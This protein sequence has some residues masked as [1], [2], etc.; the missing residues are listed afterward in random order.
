MPEEPGAHHARVVEDQQVA[1]AQEP[2]KVR[3]LEIP[4]DRIGRLQ[5]EQAGGPALGQWAL[6]DQLWGEVEAEIGAVHAAY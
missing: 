1:G 5:G 2:G 6:G 3:E 4:G